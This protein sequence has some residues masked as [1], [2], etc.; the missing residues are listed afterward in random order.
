[1]TYRDA[2][3]SLTG[4]TWNTHKILRI[5]NI[6]IQVH[7]AGDECECFAIHPEE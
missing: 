2:V 3:E 5:K 4:I 6:K 7:F 1:M